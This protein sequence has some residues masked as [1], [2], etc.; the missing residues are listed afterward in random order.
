[1]VRPFYLGLFIDISIQRN[2][3]RFCSICVRLFAFLL[4]VGAFYIF[5]IQLL[6]LIHALQIKKKKTLRVEHKTLF[7]L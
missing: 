1:M 5:C 6:C 3:K 7:T 2:V 4:K